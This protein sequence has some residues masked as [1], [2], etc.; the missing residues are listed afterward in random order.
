VFIC[1][2]Y[3]VVGVCR[4]SNKNT[5]PLFG[6][7]HALVK[8]I[9][10]YTKLLPTPALPIQ[11]PILYRF[12]KMFGANVFGASKVGYGAGYF[13]DAVVGPLLY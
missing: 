4:V 2:H 12:R 10:P 9:L 11:T 6:A 1:S 8:Q 5:I 3:K 13:K 7:S